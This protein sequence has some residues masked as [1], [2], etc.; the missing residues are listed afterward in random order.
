MTLDEAGEVVAHA[1]EPGLDPAV[2]SGQ[3][4]PMAEVEEVRGLI[5]DHHRGA[6][7]RDPGHLAQRRLGVVEWLNPPLLST[8]S[9]SRS[10]NGRSL[11]FAQNESQIAAAVAALAG[12]E[13]GRGRR[14]RR[15]RPILA[16]PTRIDAVAY[17]NAE[18]EEAGGFGRRR[19]TMS[20]ARR[21]P[22][23]KTQNA[24]SQSR[25]FGQSLLL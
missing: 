11:S 6:G 18:R 23:F 4:E 15:D 3:A 16:Q 25:T 14:R 7:F 20:R 5:S 10:R 9:N 24:H 21:S 22:P 19:S 8:A 2:K 12:G 13:L 1:H 17:G